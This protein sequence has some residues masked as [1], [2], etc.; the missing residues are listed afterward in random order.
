[1]FHRGAPD[2]LVPFLQKPFSADAL[3]STVRELLTTAPQVGKS[4][5]ALRHDSRNEG[6]I[7][8][9]GGGGKI[10]R[11]KQSRGRT[12]RKPALTGQG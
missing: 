7:G 1:M 4:P 10:P 6:L 5:Q 12:A 2:P 9:G 11:L 3:L 8:G